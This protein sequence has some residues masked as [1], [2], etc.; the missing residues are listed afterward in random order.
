MVIIFAVVV[1]FHMREKAETLRDRGLEA[2]EQNNTVAALSF[3]ERAHR[4]EKTPITCSSLAYCMAKERGQFKQA[5][6][7]CE[8]AIEKEPDSA[9]HYLNLG[10]IHILAG[11]RAEAITAFRE[12]MK[13]NLDDRI[14][15][16]LATLGIRKPP[17]IPFFKRANFLNKYLGMIFK[18]LG[19]R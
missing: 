6:A 11:N 17:V 3:L 19:F 9:A 12:G 14:I 5:F 1:K 7:L 13:H 8:E 16:E 10:R 15:A 18:R 2:L 4:L